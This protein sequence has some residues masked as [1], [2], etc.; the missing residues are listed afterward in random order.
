MLDICGFSNI[1]FAGAGLFVTD[2]QWIHP[3]RIET[4]YEII[5]VIDGFVHI[6]EESIPYTLTKNDIIILQKDVFHKGFKISSGRTSFYWIHFTADRFESIYAKPRV[7]RG[8]TDIAPFKQ[9]LH[10]SSGREYPKFFCDT[11]TLNILC[12]I[13]MF[14]DKNSGASKLV[15]EI[16]EWIRI[17]IRKR[18]NAGITAKKFSYNEE[19]LSR[20]FKKYYGLSLKEYINR[21]TVNDAKDLLCHTVYSIKEIS[22]IMGY[23]DPNTFI[24]YFKYHEGIS[25]SKFRNNLSSVHFN[26]H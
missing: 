20:L 9:L 14:S 12:E 2:E 25:P 18:L 3:A 16:A 17:N 15:R 13:I 24:N 11:F 22:A 10:I 21:E 4:T 8:Y 1:E 23:N 5:Y 26:N 6:E 19:Y 7:T